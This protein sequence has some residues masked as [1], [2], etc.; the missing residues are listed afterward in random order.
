M[1]Q[2]S[3][4]KF[5]TALANNNSKEW[6]DEN[7]KVYA[8]AKKDAEDLVNTLINLYSQNDSSISQLTAKDCFFRI[9]RDIRFSKDKSPYKT[10]FGA[11]INS[12]GK[13]S[14]KAGYYL[15]IEPGKSFIGGGVYMPM[16]AELKKFRQ[17]ID[18]NPDEFITLI[19]S[20]PFTDSYKELWREP[21]MM[22]SRVP[23]GFEKDSPVADYLK[24]K[25]FI[26]SKPLTDKDLTTVGIEKQMA[27][28]FESLQPLVQF[29]NRSL[30]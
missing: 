12:G 3:T 11:F 20:K 5:L 18:Y 17:E 7:R 28:A 29:L 15:H 1:L 14:S 13:K 2:A 8:I 16:P 10:N 27:K 9:N 6:F 21:E 25:S 30:D 23:Q 19:N 4:L 24:M 22:L 26:A